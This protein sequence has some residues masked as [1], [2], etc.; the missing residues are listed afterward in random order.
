LQVPGTRV[1]GA[2]TLSE[3]GDG[4][5]ANELRAAIYAVEAHLPDLR[6][7]TVRF[8]EDN[9]A[10][11][12]SVNK[13]SSRNPLLHK[14]LRRFWALC[15]VNSISVRMEYVRSACNP[16]DEPSRWKFR[17]EWRL[18]GPL[19]RKMEGIFGP[20]S[21]DLFASRSTHLLPRYVSR[22]LDPQAVAVDAF[23]VSWAGERCWVNADWDSLPKVA[24]RLEEDPAACATVVCPYFPGE[25]W[26]QRLRLMSV[27]MIVVP[28]DPSFAEFPQ[29]RNASGV[30]GPRD[31]S[32]AF[33][34]IPV[35]RP[36]PMALAAEARRRMRVAALQR[37]AL[38]EEQ[39]YLVLP[40]LPAVDRASALTA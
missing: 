40:L 27:D 32:L 35:R 9:Q 5:M 14:L 38:P 29:G 31:W 4:I 21:I 7:A 24:Q 13:W 10:V 12:F 3:Q 34:H 20:H 11:M 2:L 36:G 6:G 33:V 37:P 25:L 39:D 23:S 17:D 22:F 8:M 1:H 18:C 26:F 19:F 15:D 30:V 28:W 16:A